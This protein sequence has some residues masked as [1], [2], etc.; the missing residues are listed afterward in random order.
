M[1][2]PPKTRSF[3]P[4]SGTKSLIMGVRAS[5]RLPKRMV[6]SWVR[7]PTG[8]P[9]PRFTASTPAMKVVETAPIPGIR[10]PSFPSAGAIWTLSLTG[11]S[12]VLLTGVL[13]TG[14]ILAERTGENARILH[15]RI[16][17]II[18]A[19]SRY[20]GDDFRDPGG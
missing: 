10:T 2:H 18:H 6:E 19:E 13:V 12:V 7:D 20:G 16:Y 4:A 1:S 15:P 3:S 9:R 17:S 11:K 14:F 8:T 5:V